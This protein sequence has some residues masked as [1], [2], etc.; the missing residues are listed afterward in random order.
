M[1]DN[2]M[3]QALKDWIDFDPN[4]KTRSEIQRLAEN[5]AP[6][7]SQ[8]LTTRLQFGTAGLRGPMGAGNNHMNDLTV[9]QATQGLCA[10]LK[11][12]RKENKEG[13]PRKVAIG[14]DHRSLVKLGLSSKR[15][16]H[17]AACVC[18]EAGFEAHL[19]RGFT[20][21]PLIPFLV[22]HYKMDAG[23]VVTASHNPKEDNGFKVYWSSGSQIVPPHDKNIA[24]AIS[25][26]LKPWKKY[27]PEEVESHA[28]CID[29]T[30]QATGLYFKSI[31]KQ[32]C[33]YPDENKASKLKIV[34]TAMH[35]VGY[36][37]T[38]RSFKEFNLPAFYSVK[39]QQE[40][41]P[42]FPTVTF[43][44]P[45]EDGALDLALE[46]ASQVGATLVLANDPDADRLAAAEYEGN[47]KNSWKMFSG[48][49]IGIL[50]ADWQWT[51][52][53]KAN[54]SKK[55]FSD[56]YMLNSTVSSKMLRAYAAAEGFQYLDT[57]TGFKWMGNT[58]FD[59]A[60]EGKKVI[61]MFEEAIGYCVGDV[62]YDKDGVSAAA[63][64]A[65]MATYLER[66]KKMTVA[67]H[68]D[69][70]YQRL[71]YFL[72]HNY[73]VRSNDVKVMSKIFERLRNNGK[74]W[75]RCGPYT[76]KAI[77]DLKT[78]YDSSTKDQKAKLPVSNVLTY[79]FTNGCV[80]TLRPSGTE[81]KLKYYIELAGKS[82]ESTQ[83][84]LNDMVRVLV[85]ELLQPEEN[86]L[87]YKLP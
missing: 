80:I 87:S 65:E 58:A 36:S 26:N 44:N 31:K 15:F 4:P 86:G 82:V 25:E 41:D 69:S 42:S 79:E 40:P 59:L 37:F 71:G 28:A 34:Y 21:T 66:E 22:K 75:F 54:P 63:V 53:K 13:I 45:E 61:F 11:S 16:A 68:L 32:L 8:R 20:A 62:V 17:F 23:I 30:E 43:P 3:D 60:K 52:F 2:S 83:K 46:T 19:M 78:G 6:D 7:L 81:P 9:I 51:Q 56:I 1:T 57:L 29:P 39:K 48:N 77:R 47:Q 33:R 18:I 84:E 55:D 27:T 73:Y 74:Y 64:F 12:C 72:S 14:Y 10:Y 67:Q 49:E 50:L 35:G 24:K 76:I 85:M 70:L 38:S 5:K